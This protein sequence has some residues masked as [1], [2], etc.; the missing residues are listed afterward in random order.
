MDKW[1]RAHLDEWLDHRFGDYTE[2]KEQAR[3][4]IEALL[5]GDPTLIDSH[6]WPE[7][8]RMVTP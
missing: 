7:L 1:T 2:D 4:A 8:Y 5:S 3:E 6:S